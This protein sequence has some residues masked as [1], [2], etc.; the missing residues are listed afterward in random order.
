MPKWLFWGGILGMPGYA[1]HKPSHTPIPICIALHGGASAIDTLPVIHDHIFDRWFADLLVCMVF[2]DVRHAFGSVQHDILAAILCL[3]N[4][5]SHLIDIL[6]NAATGATLHMGGKNGIIEALAKFRAGIAQGCPMSALSF[7]ILL[8]LRIRM[9]LHD[10]PKP[11]S[12]CGDLGHVAY[13]Y[14]TTY[15]LDQISDIQH[16][17][18]NLYQTSIL[19]HLHTSIAKLVVPA[20]HRQGLQV[21][22]DKP[23][24]LAGGSTAPIADGKCTSDFWE[25]M[26]CHTSFIPTIS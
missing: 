6:M 2:D 9:V 22:F 10:I 21:I 15:L 5:P 20:V 1:H 24:I 23:N 14:D 3:L 19:T 8:E 16:L 13:M 12:K 11:R 17:L 25:G 18:S 26:L 4:F 7:C